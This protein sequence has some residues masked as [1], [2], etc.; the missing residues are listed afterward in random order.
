MTMQVIT[1]EGKLPSLKITKQ[2]ANKKAIQDATSWARKIA[3]DNSYHYKK[4]KG[5]DKKT[6][7]CPICKKYPKGKYHGWN[8]IGFAFATW[9]HGMGIKSAC[10]CYVIS[11]EVAQ[12][13]FNADTVAKATKIAKEHLKNNDITVIRK[14]TNISKSEFK[15]GDICLSFKNKK[16]KHTWY[17][18]GK[19]IVIDATTKKSEKAQIAVRNS[20]KYTAAIIIRYTGR[21]KYGEVAPLS[22]YDP[23]EDQVKEWQIYINW[24]YEKKVI[25]EDGVFGDKTLDY[26]KKVQKKLGIKDNGLVNE[27]TIKEAKLYKK[28]IVKESEVSTKKYTGKIPSLKIT[29]TTQQVI[30]DTVKWAYWIARDNRFHYGYTNK[31][32]TPWNPNAHHNGC[33][34]CGTNTISGSRSKKGIKDYK[35][36]YCC[37]PFV[38]AAWAHG[39][40]VP[41][42]LSMCQKGGSWSFGKGQGYD[43]CDLFKKMHHPVM[44]NL[45]KG[46][47]LCSDSHIALYVGDGKIAEAGGGDDNIKN[48]KSWN[49]SI[50]DRVLS[51]ENYK[52]FKRVYRFIGTVNFET[53]LRH[54]E[55]SDRI[56]EWQSFLDW[57]FKGKVGKPD[58]YFGDNT[59]KW[60]KKFQ[61]E[62]GLIDDGVIGE[63]TLAKARI[64]EL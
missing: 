6:K 39:G 22:L 36:T 16:Y 59:L 21:G 37:N 52:N 7:E 10:N 1:Y 64:V 18:G 45:K 61:D 32:V 19:D 23:R 60:T 53:A 35:F 2:Q 55:I 28:T 31:K 38:G 51:S 40:C 4:W 44:K 14:K 63:K 42:A 43:I 9:H 30:D 11:N 54:G 5:S 50:R 20:D 25:T 3:G 12:K 48:S 24:V 47:V 49:N 41:K 58:R 46:D 17:C 15:E 33:Y 27:N 56:S 29:K 13:M 26:T 34:F 62:N 8:C 57:Y